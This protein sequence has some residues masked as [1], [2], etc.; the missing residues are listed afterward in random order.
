MNMSN[1]DL[2][3]LDNIAYFTELYD[4]YS[5]NKENFTISSIVKISEMFFHK[6]SAESL[7]VITPLKLIAFDPKGTST[8]ESAILL[9]TKSLFF[10]ISI[11]RKTFYYMI[12][13]QIPRKCYIP[14]HI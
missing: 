1:N 10:F 5:E 9:K 11:I 13:Q 3:L 14:F 2:I 6:N 12:P 4:K 7:S 8:L